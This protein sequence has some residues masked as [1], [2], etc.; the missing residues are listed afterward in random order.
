MTTNPT[1]R[2]NHLVA[3]FIGIMAMAIPFPLVA[4]DGKVTIKADEIS[5]GDAFA[6]IER[7]TGYSIAYGQSV[8]DIRKTIALS[9]EG[10]SIDEAMTEVLKSTGLTYKTN[11]YHIILTPKPQPPQVPQPRKNFTVSGRITDAETGEVIIGCM[12]FDRAS[13]RGTTTNSYGFY[14]LTLPA[15]T[16]SIATSF[17][18]Y[19]V[20]EKVIDLDKDTTLNLSLKAGTISLE[21]VVVR[22]EDHNPLTSKVG[23]TNIPLSVIRNAP[24]LMGESDLMKSLRYIP[25]VQNSS[26]GKSDLSIRGGSPDQNLI[27]LDGNP[28]YNANHVFG[29]ISV[30]NT[31]ALKNVT[32][33]KSG[34]PAR[35]G[36]RLS[37]VIDI[38]TKDGDKERFGGSATL[39]LLAVKFSLEGPI[40][41]DKTSFTLS[42][43]RSWADIF[44][45]SLQKLDDVDDSRTNF[46]FYDLNAK[47]HHKF[48]DRT[49][50]YLSAYNGLDVLKNTIRESP[51][52]EPMDASTRQNWKWGNTLF[53]TRLNSALSGKLFMNANLSYNRYMYN[54]SVDNRYSF[55]DE[56][57][58][59][60]KGNRFIGYDSGIR[61]YTGSVEFEYIPAPTHYIRTGVQYVYHDFRPETIS[62]SGETEMNVN[63]TMVGA[64]EFAVYAEDDWDIARRLELNGGVR[65]SL[66]D[67]AGKTY[68]AIDPRLSMRLHLTDRMT[69]KA[70]YSRM[71]QYIHLLSNN[72]LLLQADLWVPTTDKVKPMNSTQYSLGFYVAFPKLFDVSVEG[73]YKDMNNVIEYKD[74]ASFAVATGGWEDMVEAGKGRSYGVEVSMERRIGKT[75]GTMSYAWSKTERRFEGINYGE[76]FP[77]KFDRTHSFNISVTHKFNETFD[78]TASWTFTSGNMMTVPMVR[79]VKPDVPDLTTPVHTVPDSGNAVQFDHRNNYRMPPHHRLDIGMNFYP[80]K[81][82]NPHR[83][84]VWNFSIYNVYNRMNAFKIYTEID[85]DREGNDS[86]KLKQ[87]TMF[88]ILP[89]ISYTYNF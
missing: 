1:I 12:V 89:S 27:L 28:I 39:G 44:A 59:K 32:L 65:F 38:N 50:I 7:Q 61:D 62:R 9:L 30:F 74:G 20:F 84:G 60:K 69:I 73:Y 75:T 11:G 46:F 18:G 37:S 67:V 53:A 5:I 31:D 21:E 87:I 41:K 86:Y 13:N 14:S 4:Q 78:M 64:N 33:Y 71:Q 79:V 23:A 45:G 26:E 3:I 34:F 6:R 52:D 63:P 80:R 76:W 82:R 29:F 43:R 10:A 16:V 72:S 56:G 22:P 47:I 54:T 88:P 25:G 58:K 17:L 49:S 15:G 48:S 36:G 70:G 24:V 85:L 42:A 2:R 35:F 51:A 40:V 19:E 57:G 68:S 55:E 81:A 77:A 8:L 83:Y 66:F